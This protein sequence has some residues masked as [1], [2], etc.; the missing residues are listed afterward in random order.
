MPR[1]IRQLEADLRKEG[2]TRQPGKGSHRRW[3]HPFYPGHVAISGNE[4]DDAKPYQERKV[5]DAIET[6]REARRRRP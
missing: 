4:G 2:F 5:R 1:K 6:V 3:M